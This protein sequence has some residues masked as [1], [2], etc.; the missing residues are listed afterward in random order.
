MLFVV[1]GGVPDVGGL[2][3]ASFPSD[4]NFGSSVSSRTWCV[5]N[6]L[7][8]PESLLIYSFRWMGEKYDGVRL[9]WNASRNSM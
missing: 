1:F 9:C 5:F 4:P 6:N 2:M 8:T 7:V 3:L